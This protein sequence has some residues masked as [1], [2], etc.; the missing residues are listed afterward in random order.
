MSSKLKRDQDSTDYFCLTFHQYKNAPYFSPCSLDQWGFLQ[1][2]QNDFSS[3]IKRWSRWCLLNGVNIFVLYTFQYVSQLKGLNNLIKKADSVP[4]NEEIDTSN[5]PTIKLSVL[6]PNSASEIRKLGLTKTQEVSIFCYKAEILTP[7]TEFHSVV[8]HTIQHNAKYLIFTDKVPTSLT[9][10]LPVSK[11]S[12]WSHP[13]DLISAL[14]SPTLVPILSRDSSFKPPW[15]APF[16]ATVFKCF[17]RQES[18]GNTWLE[19][20]LE[21]N[22]IWR[23]WLLCQAMNLK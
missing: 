17:L 13:H 22:R 10:C 23:S 11:M 7:T 6:C 8:N 15:H 21:R 18:W 9:Y 2:K 4:K 19:T 20:F 1:G 5:H 12:L 14:T 3:Q 16:S